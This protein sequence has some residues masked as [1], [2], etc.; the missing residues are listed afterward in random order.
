MTEPNAPEEGATPPPTP[1][2]PQPPP[3]GAGPAIQDAGGRFLPESPDAKTMGML[4]HLLG[5]FTG[6]LGPLIIWLVK[7]DQSRFVDQEGKEAL[8]F[9]LT[10]LIAYVV[11]IL[12]WCLFVGILIFIAAWIIDIVFCILASVSVNNG[13]PYRYPVCIRMIK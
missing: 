11:G 4:A 3:P 5:F 7:K 13:K 1:Q 2:P 12:T 6:F 9:Q 10:V 8:N